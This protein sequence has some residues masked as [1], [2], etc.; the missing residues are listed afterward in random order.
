MRGAQLT[1]TF[2]P[3]ELDCYRQAWAQPRAMRN[4][5]NWYRALWRTPPQPP[6]HRRIV[7]P[8]L[9]LWGARDRFLNRELAPLSLARCDHGRLAW[10]ETATHWLQHEQPETVNQLL[11]E[12]LR[13]QGNGWC[14]IPGLQSRAIRGVLLALDRYATTTKR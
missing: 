8:A 7:M 5:M 9:I 12:F 1:Q 4:M 6:V 10:L 11:L 3:A 13:E 2:S 14:A